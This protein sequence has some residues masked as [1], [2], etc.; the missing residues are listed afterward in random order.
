MPANRSTRIAWA[1]GLC[2][3]TVPLSRLSRVQTLP[4]AAALPAPPAPRSPS[5]AARRDARHYLTQAQKAVNQEREALEAWDLAGV[6]SLDQEHFRRQLMA[7][8]PGG[9]LRRALEA[10]ERAAALART[11]EEAYAAALLLARLECDAGHHPEELRQARKLMALQPHD[12][13]SLLALRRAAFCNEM[14]SL[15]LRASEE[16]N[17]RL[18]AV[19]SK[20]Y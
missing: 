20:G 1:L 18:P 17:W 4:P 6:D 15:A 9:H 2:L 8:D 11:P 14:P 12:W 13:L 10:G 16:L 19:K 5:E 3:L 7:A